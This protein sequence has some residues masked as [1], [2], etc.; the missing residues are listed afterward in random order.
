VNGQTIV[1]AKPPDGQL[2]VYGA[3]LARGIWP[4]APTW[5]H[6]ATGA[7]QATLT[8]RRRADVQWSDL[9][10][11]TPVWVS[12]NGQIGFQ[13]RIRQTPSQRDLA[14]DTITVQLEGLTANLVDD[15]LALRS[16]TADLNDWVDYRSTTHAD[17]AGDKAQVDVQIGNGQI[18]MQA[19]KGLAALA[20]LAGRCGIWL[21]AGPGRTWQNI[22]ISSYRYPNGSRA[23]DIGA[24][25]TLE[26]YSTDNGAHLGTLGAAAA[27]GTY[28]PSGLDFSASPSRGIVLFWLPSGSATLTNDAQVVISGISANADQVEY[29]AAGGGNGGVRASYIVGKAL[30]K[31][32]SINPSRARIAATS[33]AIPHFEGGQQSPLSYIQ[34]ANDYHLWQFFLRD[35]A[36]G[37]APVPV[38]RAVPTV[39]TLVA[40]VGQ[41]IQW[42]DASRGDGS[43]VYNRVIV[44][45]QDGTGVAQEVTRAAGALSG[46]SFTQPS[47]AQLINGDF[48]GP[49]NTVGS[50]ADDWTEVLGTNVISSTTPPSGSTKYM[51]VTVDVTG[52]LDQEEEVPPGDIVEG[53][54]Y[55]L[56]F[57][58]QTANNDAK[59]FTVSVDQFSAN[60]GD[61]LTTGTFT[62]A[63]A[64]GAWTTLSVDF[65]GARDLNVVKVIVATNDAT[66]ASRAFGL[67]DFKIVEARPTLWDRQGIVRTKVL[68]TSARMTATAAAQ[69][70]DAFLTAHQRTP[71]KGTLTVQGSSLRTFLGDVPVPAAIVGARYVQDPVL[72]VDTDPDLSDVTRVGIVAATSYVEATD[73]VKIQVDQRRDFLDALQARLAVEQG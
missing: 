54:A 57:R 30:D 47:A 11:G 71:L 64:F 27:A 38:Y 23:A 51:A 16:V 6:A 1:Y 66:Q 29:T 50:P 41:G 21:D 48:E 8:L 62:Y 32:P 49:L 24:Q 68:Q 10:A 18:T 9:I 2:E 31:C 44:Q 60:L 39:P 55:R 20:S 52:K 34:A 13:G 7:E 56:L 15:T 19:P 43:D 61:T 5:D 14:G 28:G 4:E 45:Y 42:E 37:E 58:C 53:R 17:P 35:G 36:A 46:V 26:L 67:D 3:G 33:F 63:Q 73:E 22:V 40:R 65:I 72:I 12:R 69:I 70:G 25:Y 59:T